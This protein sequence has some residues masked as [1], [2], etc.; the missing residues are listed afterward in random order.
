[1]SHQA[2]SASLR[3]SWGCLYQWLNMG[4]QSCPVCKAGV[5]REN[6]IPLYTSGSGDKASH[7]A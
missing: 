3:G 6:I 7:P 1:M 4:R 2:L 5:T